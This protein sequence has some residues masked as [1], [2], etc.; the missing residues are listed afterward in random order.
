MTTHYT[1]VLPWTHRW[2]PTRCVECNTLVTSITGTAALV[3]NT[4]TPAA[5]E[6]YIVAR[7]HN[8]PQWQFTK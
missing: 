1:S 7:C 2:L 5:I 6:G 8:C 4:D 3:R